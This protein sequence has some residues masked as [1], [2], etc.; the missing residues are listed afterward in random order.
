MTEVEETE[1]QPNL[2][3]DDQVRGL[4]V[5]V[6]GDGSGRWRQPETGQ[7]LCAPSSKRAATQRATI[8]N[9][10]T[11]RLSRTS[12][13]TSRSN[14]GSNERRRDSPGPRDLPFQFICD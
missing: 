10:I 14:C 12:S 5:R 13:N 2:V 4:C 7:S 8:A 1:P 9:A 11:F 3:W 6:Y